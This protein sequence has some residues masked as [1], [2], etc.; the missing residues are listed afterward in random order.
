MAT[1]L[2][3]GAS[4]FIGS[5]FVEEGLKR[6]YDVYAG[7]RKSSS[8]KYL[9]DPRIKFAEF[10]FSTAE[11]VQAV[12]AE[13]S[14]RGVRFDYIIH[15][16]GV[17]KTKKKEDF[18][19]VN[20]LNTRNFIEA[21]IAS[22]MVPEKFIYMSSLAAFGPGDP[23]TGQ[24]VRLNDTPKPIELYGF[25]KLEAEK[26]ITGLSGFP[27]LIFRP[28]G[29]YGPRETDYFV[30]FQTINRGLEPY[31]GFKKQVLTFIYVRDLVRLI[32]DALKSPHVRKGYFV[33]DGNEYPSE[34]F[35]EI[36]KK[37]LSKKTV[38]ITIPKF[39]VKFIAVSGEKIAGLWGAVPTLNSD[40]YNVLSSTNWRCDVEPLRQDFN[41]KAE[42]DL[43]KGVSEAIAW[44]RQEGWL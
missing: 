34:L 16:A 5:F 41:F 40:K 35:A 27:W 30:F 32:F 14:S 3:T 20:C 21:L 23:V 18:N 39:L 26:Y 13:Y 9:Q 2:I 31:I 6:G 15:S 36:T 44:Y 37:I 1:I 19:R 25:S 42:Y 4:G 10:D 33:A 11:K 7:V 22:G 38:R 12:L 17:T 8:R 29:V 43:E 28:T 24:P